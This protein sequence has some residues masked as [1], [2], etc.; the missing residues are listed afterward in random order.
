[1]LKLFKLNSYAKIN[2]TLEI[3]GKRED[4]FHEISSVFQTISLHDILHFQEDSELVVETNLENLNTQ[5]NLVYRAGKLLKDFMNV[6]FGAK[7]FVDKNIPVAAGLGG[8]SSNAATTLIGLNKLWNLNLNL[9]QLACLGS[10]LGSDVSFFL[11]GGTAHV[12]GKGEIV[13]KLPPL[14]QMKVILIF[15][16]NCLSTVKK[17][18]TALAYSFLNEKNYTNGQNTDNLLESIYKT[19]RIDC[20]KFFNSFQDIYPKVFND[21]LNPFNL[22]N[23]QGVMKCYVSGS[24]PALFIPICDNEDQYDMIRKANKICGFSAISTFFIEECFDE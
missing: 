8:G 23:Q 5:D 2:L 20:S 14:N 17:N 24:G 10:Q 15:P 18:K 11:Y 6:K 7:I 19:N 9:E 1:M 21:Y 16:N 13:S 3:L 22:L 12:S 4:G